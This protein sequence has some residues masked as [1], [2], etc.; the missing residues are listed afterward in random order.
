METTFL[1]II[2]KGSFKEFI[3]FCIN[4]YIHTN[5]NTNESIIEIALKNNNFSL[6][7]SLLCNGLILNDN[8]IK[9]IKNINNINNI[10]N[11]IIINIPSDNNDDILGWIYH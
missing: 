11:D 1:N 3:N 8:E 10:N 6:I 4:N 7:Q 5:I 2:E 9:M